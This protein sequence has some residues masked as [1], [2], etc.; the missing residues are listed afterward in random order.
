[1]ATLTQSESA[2]ISRKLEA[3]IALT[4]QWDTALKAAA[5]TNI[6]ALEASKEATKALIETTTKAMT[7]AQELIEKVIEAGQAAET[8]AI[9]LARVN[10]QF[11]ATSGSASNP[12]MDL[13]QSLNKNPFNA[14]DY[15]SGA[16]MLTTEQKAEFLRVIT[17]QD[18]A[19][20]DSLIADYKAQI[21]EIYTDEYKSI[22]AKKEKLD[23]EEKVIGKRVQDLLTSIK[24]KENTADYRKTIDLIAKLRQDM[25]YLD[26][27]SGILGQRIGKFDQDALRLEGQLS[28]LNR[29]W[30]DDALQRRLSST[31]TGGTGKEAYGY[32]K[33]ELLWLVNKALETGAG[34]KVDPV[35]L[36][37][38]IKKLDSAVPTKKY[39]L[40]LTAGDQ[41]LSAF[42]D[43]S[44]E[45]F[46]EA[47]LKARGT[48]I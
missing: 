19:A 43:L 20:L 7:S 12:I 47:L 18:K 21:N 39:Q 34:A 37:E 44:P 28:V 45:K 14:S 30:D 26:Q 22:K 46:I 1:M 17:D 2:S 27:Q 33:D 8:T 40:D 29:A 42:T 24:G 4:A 36:T 41:K 25:N 23:N 31:A 5:D 11:Q 32:T 16:S 6:E 9:Q 35:A 15:L 38:L 13:Q 3:L 10:A 48:A